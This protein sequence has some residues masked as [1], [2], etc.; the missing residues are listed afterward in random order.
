MY[1]STPA[2]ILFLHHLPRK[3]TD[4]KMDQTITRYILKGGCTGLVARALDSKARG[5][6]FDPHSGRRAVYLSK[7]Y[8]LP[9]ITGNTQEMVAPSHHD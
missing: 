2:L 4:E 1:V 7:T 3:N 6:G 8:L 5:P 9:R